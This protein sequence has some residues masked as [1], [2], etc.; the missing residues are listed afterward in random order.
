MRIA[1]LPGVQMPQPQSRLT[2]LPPLALMGTGTPLV[3]SLD[4]YL[5][6]MARACAC[7][8]SALHTSLMVFAE[9]QLGAPPARDPISRLDGLIRSI[10]TLAGRSDAHC[11]STWALRFILSARRRSF[12]LRSRRW[13]P[14]CY[15]DWDVASSCEPLAWSF[16]RLTCCPLHLVRLQSRCSECGS[17]Q[18]SVRP[19]DARRSCSK[20]GASLGSTRRSATYAA[21]AE[22]L[23]DAIVLDIAALCGDPNLTV[24]PFERF[25]AL[26]EEVLRSPAMAS[27]THP[28]RQKMTW[29][30]VPKEGPS[31]D[32]LIN[33]SALLGPFPSVLLLQPGSA[34]QLSLFNSPMSS[35]PL[36]REG[37]VAKCRR[38]IRILGLL[39]ARPS[40]L[41]PIGVILKHIGVSRATMTSMAG[42]IIAAYQEITTL[43]PGQ[44]ERR[45]KIAI[46]R[47][48]FLVPRDS[49]L[50]SRP[51]CAALISQ[52]AHQCRISIA[53][54]RS[55]FFRVSRYLRASRAVES[56]IKVPPRREAGD[57]KPNRARKRSTSVGKE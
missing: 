15:A 30:L 14:L 5:A 1:H 19:Y 3:E 4:H 10:G 37:A 22:R 44:P 17:I 34:S 32:A 20:C 18:G 36:L 51:E 52:V 9:E 47:L 43:P 6:R 23:V 28:Q 41:V 40:R 57:Q 53:A 16:P 49:E 45:L 29:T 33:L 48:L 11:G 38:T 31:F 42:P 7:S 54:A 13:C 56:T 21:P 2:V 39:R 25:S 24:I 12:N 8:V 26:R 35:L 27:L 55:L 50:P 46:W